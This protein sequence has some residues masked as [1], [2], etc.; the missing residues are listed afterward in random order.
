MSATAPSVRTERALVT[1]EAI[2]AAAERLFAE[3]GLSNVSHRQIAEA[4]GQRNVA[5]VGYHFGS[6]TDLVRALMA[7][8]GT[9][10]DEI[11]SRYVARVEGSED[12]RDWVGAL[13]RPVTDHLGSLGV[14]S[15]NARLSAQV[16]T[17]PQLR[18]VVIE[19]AVE[20]PRLRPILDGLGARLAHVPAS[21]RAARGDMAR[22]LIIHTCA[23]R[24]RALAE[25]TTPLHGS[26]NDTAD[27][28]TDALV[29]LFTAPVTRPPT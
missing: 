19:E 28:L 16:L 11:R 4:A 8:H 18:A 1:R 26:W 9:P 2:L 27:A 14:P 13:V 7:R 23:D 15:W 21:V 12:I 24:E 25:Q 3:H 22:H 20:R 10:V 17:D 29:G 6:R 5:A